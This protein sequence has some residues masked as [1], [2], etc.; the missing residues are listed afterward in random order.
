MTF[1]SDYGIWEPKWQVEGFVDWDYPGRRVLRLPAGERRRPRR[2]SSASTRPSS[3]TSRSRP[4]ASSRT[5][6]APAARDDAQLVV[7]LSD[8][9]TARARRAATLGAGAGRAGAR[10]AT[11][12]WTSRSRRS[13]SWRRA[14]CR[15]RRHGRGAPAA[16]D[17]LLRAELRV[18][19][20]RRRLRRGRA[21]AGRASGG[22]GP[23][24]PL[25]RRRDQR[26]VAARAGFVGS[27][28]GEAVGDW[29]TCAPT[30]CARPCWPAPTGSAGRCSRAGRTR[31]SWPR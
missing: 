5:R 17:V 6:P 8:G 16:A 4:S 7:G 27:F 9:G 11:R 3:T 28:G 19:D 12:S 29:T 14:R 23:R 24:R 10:C 18:P 2:R 21:R 26:G 15:R 20:G 13:A 22:G 30:S 25:R 31:R 1:G